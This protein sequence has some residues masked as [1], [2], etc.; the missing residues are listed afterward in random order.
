MGLLQLGVAA[1]AQS[2]EQIAQPCTEGTEKLA[3]VLIRV[4]HTGLARPPSLE[5]G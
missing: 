4:S 2:G 1:E 5:G 3:I